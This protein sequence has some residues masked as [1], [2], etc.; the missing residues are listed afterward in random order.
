MPRGGAAVATPPARVIQSERW[1]APR[2]GSREIMNSFI[3][4]EFAAI[5]G[6]AEGTT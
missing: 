4:D 5:G 2:I 6:R 1:S 3:I